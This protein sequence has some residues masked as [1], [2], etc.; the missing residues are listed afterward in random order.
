MPDIFVSAPGSVTSLQTGGSV[1]GGYLTIYGEDNS[2]ASA[3]RNRAIITGINFKQTT[4]QSFMKALDKSFYVFPFDDNMGVAQVRGIIF[5][6]RCAAGGGTIDSHGIR[7]VL[8]FYREN[9]LVMPE[10]GRSLRKVRI[11]VGEKS[12]QGFLVSCNIDA[13]GTGDAST[14]PTAKFNMNILTMTARQ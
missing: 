8:E 9:R 13:L 7:S 14:I 10:S 4:S 12:Y 1:R 6:Q 11:I 3:L 2:F 5:Y